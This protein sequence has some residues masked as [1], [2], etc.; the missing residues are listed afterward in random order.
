MKTG[1]A[2]FLKASDMAKAVIAFPGEDVK[3]GKIIDAMRHGI[4]SRVSASEVTHQIEHVAAQYGPTTNL[5]PLIYGIQGNR[6]L[7]ASKHQGQAL[8][9]VH[10]EAPL[11]QVAS[12]NPRHSRSSEMVRLIVPTAPKHVRERRRHEDRRRLHPHL[13]PTRAKDRRRGY[14][15][16]LRPNFPLAAKT[17]LHNTLLVKVGDASRPGSRSPSRTSPRT[18]RSRSAP[19]CASATCRTAA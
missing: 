6:V 9:L 13:E 14:P 3:P 11:V 1:A 10:R 8:P 7:M 5:L 19:T 15:P 16:P 12:W 2:T 4:V 17:T 18:A